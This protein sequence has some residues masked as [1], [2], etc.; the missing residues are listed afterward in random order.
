MSNID[1]TT[2]KVLIAEFAP[3]TNLSLKINLYVIWKKNA[4]INAG[5][6]IRNKSAKI[7]LNSL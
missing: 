2:A 4:K 1:N 7:N 3:K 5:S 6:D